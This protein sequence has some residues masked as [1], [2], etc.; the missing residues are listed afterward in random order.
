MFLSIRPPT[1]QS[2]N[3]LTP[4]D[5]ANEFSISKDTYAKMYKDGKL[6]GHVVNENLINGIVKQNDQNDVID[7]KFI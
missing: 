1:F 6:E 2:N 4:N 3:Y 7:S 5:K